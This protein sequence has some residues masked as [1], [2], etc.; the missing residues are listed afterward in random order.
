MANCTLKTN[1]EGY[2]YYEIRVRRGRGLPTLSTTWYVPDGW[3][4]R[5]IDRELE[6]IAA[7]FE[8]KA[9]AGEIISRKEQKELAALAEAEAAKICTFQQYAEKS[10]PAG[11]EDNRV[12]AHDRQL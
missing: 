4:K 3:S 1:S 5:A 7:E 9:K 2:Q 11:F 12:K 8:R 10:L 6:K